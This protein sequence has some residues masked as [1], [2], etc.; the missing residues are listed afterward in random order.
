MAENVEI[1]VHVSAPGTTKDDATYRAHADAYLDFE[2]VSR[3]CIYPGPLN[4][5]AAIDEPSEAPQ[6]AAV[7][8][9]RHESGIYSEDPTSLLNTSE[10]SFQPYLL[11]AQKSTPLPSTWGPSFGDT[12]FGILDAPNDSVI[13][14][15][16]TQNDASAAADNTF[17][18]FL[19]PP[20]TPDP[21]S[22]KPQETISSSQSSE[23]PPS[24]VPESPLSFQASW[25]V[26]KDNSPLRNPAQ[27]IQIGRSPSLD[28]SSQSKRRR[29]SLSPA[30]IPSSIPEGTAPTSSISEPP[31]TSQSI[32]RPDL[33]LGTPYLGASVQEQALEQPS[34]SPLEIS[35]APSIP[36]SFISEPSQTTQPATQQDTPLENPPPDPRRETLSRLS[37]LPLEINAPRP[38]PSSTAEFTTHITPTLQMLANQLKLSRVFKPS[39]QTRRL[40]ALERGYWALNLFISTTASD[41]TQP[42]STTTSSGQW[43]WTAKCFF[44]FWDFLSKFIAHDGRAGWGVWC[45]CDSNPSSS[46]SPARLTA[47][48]TDT[49]PSII[50]LTTTQSPLHPATNINTEPTDPTPL[51]VKIYTWGEIAPH[52]YLL[53]YLASDRKVRKVRGVEWRDGAD[54]GVV[55][56]D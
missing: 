11:S 22:S 33:P 12:I 40:R 6:N 53:M 39:R 21:R 23:T 48:A 3:V 28:Q 15:S 20:I 43:T 30:C 1:L 8:T 38:A 16:F 27:F 45:I 55:F 34:S 46:S 35:A 5:E 47:T 36:T 31:T 49:P 52:I 4:G 50:D 54:E 18:S 56:M 44:D 42:T 2:P 14:K 29:L 19:I 17:S 26:E 32:P 41:E 37:S 7:S 25:N 51:T 10:T 13:Q 24:V 9:P